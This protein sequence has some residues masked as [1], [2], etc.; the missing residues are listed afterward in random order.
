MLHLLKKKK[1]SRVLAKCKTLI[2]DAFQSFSSTQI[3]TQF[4][5]DTSSKIMRNGLFFKLMFI[6]LSFLIIS[7]LRQDCDEWIKG[8]A[9]I[10]IIFEFLS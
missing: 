4:D 2:L 10:V 3:G 8:R 5:T 6:C 7:R 9:Y 1:K